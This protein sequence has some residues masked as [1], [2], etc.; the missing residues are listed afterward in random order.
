M[1]AE[2]EKIR[3][4]ADFKI[5]SGSEPPW[6][7]YQYMKLREAVDAILGG[8]KTVTPTGNLQQ[9]PER[10]GS[11]LRLV[12]SKSQP[13]SAPRHPAGLPVRMPT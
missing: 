1:R 2:L 3:E 10:T 13:D 4:W 8:M 11:G 12:G 6:A 5:A 7:W 9:S